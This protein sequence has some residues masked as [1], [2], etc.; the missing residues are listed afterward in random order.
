MEEKRI[1]EFF[2]RYQDFFR[3][4]LKNEADMEQVALSYATAFIAASPAGVMA[5]QNDE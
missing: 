3:Q 1:H 2:K 4:G 5:G